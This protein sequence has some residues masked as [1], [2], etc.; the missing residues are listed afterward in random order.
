MKTT[1]LLGVIF[2]AFAQFSSAEGDIAINDAWVREVPPGSSVSAIYMTIQSNGDED[3]KL[4]SMS[5]K[6]A[7]SAELHT[8]KVDSN[9]VATMEMIEVLDIP[10]N[11]SIDFQP[12][13]MHIMLIGLKESLVGKDSVNLKLVFEKAGEVMIEVPVKKGQEGGH[14][15]HH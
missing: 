14:K 2:F 4:V 8:S 3:D 6:A 11:N 13:G 12:G 15:H 1:L 5:S 7:E 10:S 9:G